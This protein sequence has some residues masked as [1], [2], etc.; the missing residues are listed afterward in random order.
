MGLVEIRTA[1]A[2]EMGEVGDIR[3][4][5]YQSG[6]YMSPDSGY[7]PILRG[8]G[9]DGNGEVL[10]AIAINGHAER[11]IGTIMLQLWPHAGEV[12]TGPHEAEIRALAVRPEA[13]GQGVGR[14]LL[15][16]VL[17][18]AP[19]LGVSHLVLCTTPQM[20]AAHHLY[21]QEG[22]VRL[23]E[24]DWFPAPDEPLL[25]YGLRLNGSPLA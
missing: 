23:Q 18:R 20:R 1:T 16:H 11:I 4:A 17:G 8:L 9:A 25:V 2:A 10:V 7:A 13:Q 6:G 21:E 24:R 5:A 14:Q 12:V 3:I 22:F 19:E 15:R